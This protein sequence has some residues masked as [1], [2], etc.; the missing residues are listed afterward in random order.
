MRAG[1]EFSALD[2]LD[3]SLWRMF[4]LGVQIEMFNANDYRE[5]ADYC[6]DDLLWVRET[7]KYA[8]ATAEAHLVW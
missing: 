6:Q 1:I 7:T 3:L 4:I 5:E 8:A 2:S